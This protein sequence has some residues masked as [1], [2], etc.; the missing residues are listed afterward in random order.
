MLDYLTFSD[1]L[2]YITMIIGYGNTDVKVFMVSFVKK[3]LKRARKEKN[4]RYD[5]VSRAAQTSIELTEFLKNIV[6]KE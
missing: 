5:F 2:Y 4:A 3:G 6:I 1:A